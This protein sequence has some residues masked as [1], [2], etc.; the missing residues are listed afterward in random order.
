MFEDDIQDELID[1]YN[2]FQKLLDAFNRIGVSADIRD[3]VLEIVAAILHLGNIEF[4]D[5]TVGFKS[6][7]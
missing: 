3:T 7:L 5:E 6:N 2:D 1:D 4:F